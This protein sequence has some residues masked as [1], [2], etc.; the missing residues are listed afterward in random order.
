MRYLSNVEL[1]SVNCVKPEESVKALLFSSK[2]LL[3]KKIKL[4][5]HYR[6]DNLPANIEFIQ[7]E[8]QTHSSMNHFMLFELPKYVEEEFILSIHDDGFIINPHLWTDTFLEYDY[9]GAP[10]PIEAG[11]CPV[12]RVGNGGFVLKSN[13]FMQLESLL[14]PTG[15][16]N[17]VYV[18]N[19]CYDYFIQNGC[20]YA[21]IEVAMRFSLESYIPECEYDLDKVFGFHGRGDSWIFRDQGQQFKDRISLLNNI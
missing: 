6:P 12:N 14:P 2:S 7:I 8:K 13:R 5:A 19:T 9:V 4:F 1:I 17:D 11:W 15:Q 10:W 21:P 18:T 3:F 16:N 20:K